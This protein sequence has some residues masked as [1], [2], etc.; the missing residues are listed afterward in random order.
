M[1]HHR[2]QLLGDLIVLDL[3]PAT[4]VQELTGLP[5]VETRKDELLHEEHR[6]LEPLAHSVR[7]QEAIG[8]FAVRTSRGDQGADMERDSIDCYPVI[9][10]MSQCCLCFVSSSLFSP[11]NVMELR[12]EL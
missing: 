9:A 5:H 11:Q 1:N 6:H 10:S 12:F 2:P 4:A 7:E 8:P 3:P